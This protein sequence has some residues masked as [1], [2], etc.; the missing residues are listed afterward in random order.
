MV[1]RRAGGEKGIASVE[2]LEGDAV[3]QWRASDQGRWSAPLLKAALAR[4]PGPKKKRPAGKASTPVAFRLEYADGF[5][6]V[7][8]MLNGQATG[9]TFAA[10]LKD[11][12]EPLST[13][14]GFVEEGHRTLPHFDGLVK[15]IEDLFVTGQPDYPVERTLLTTGA[16]ALLFESRARK[17]R[18]ETPQLAIRYHAPR[19]TFYQRS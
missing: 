18:V 1:E 13:H 16:L 4:D 19:D 6:A 3:A 12:P 2:W 15:C 11:R 9:W 5:R 10:Q 8:Y 17:Q 7:A 14:F